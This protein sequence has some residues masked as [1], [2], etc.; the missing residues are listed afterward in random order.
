MQ[1]A[2]ALLYRTYLRI[3]FTKCVEIE[4]C[5]VRGHPRRRAGSYYSGLSAWRYW[6]GYA[7]L[8]AS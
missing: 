8:T 1:D 4:F 2:L 6:S 5:E 7:L 3:L